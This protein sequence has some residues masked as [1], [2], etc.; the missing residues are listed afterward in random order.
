MRKQTRKERCDNL[1]RLFVDELIPLLAPPP[2][3]SIAEWADQN[4][5]LG[6]D[7]TSQPGPWRTDF[8]PYQRGIMEAILEPNTERIVVMKAARIGITYSAVLNPVGYYIDHNP[9]PL[10]VAYPTVDLAKKFSKKYLSPFLRDCK[11]ISGLVASP[12]SRDGDN[13]ML[14]K[15]FKN[16]AGTLTLIGVNSP[17]AMRMDTARFVVLDEADGEIEIREGNFVKLL[18]KRAETYIGRGKVFVIIS[19]PRDQATSVVEPEYLNSTMDQWCLPCPSCGEMQPLK[20][21]QI[22]FDTATHVCKEC[23]VLHNKREWL[24]GDGQ[25]ISQNPDATT[26]GFHINALP[27]PFVSWEAL[28]EDFR[29]AMAKSNAGDNSDLQ[30]FVNTVLAETWTQ[31][32]ARIDETGLMARREEYYADVPDGVCAITVAVDTQDNRLAVD[33]V[34]WGAG[35]ESWRLE[36]LELWGDTRVPGSPVW[37]Q[38]DEVLRTPR[39]YANG[40]TVPVVCTVI[41]MGGHAADQVCTYAKAR[42]GWNVWAIR[43]VGGWGKQLVHSTFKSKVASATAFNLAVDGGKDQVTALLRVANPGPGY[44]HFPR[45][46]TADYT[47]AYESVRGYDERYFAG[48]TAEKKVSVKVKGGFHRYEWQKQQGAANEPFDLAVYNLAAL[49]ISKV[50]LE[51]IAE[52]APW[53]L[54]APLSDVIEQPSE[55]AATRVPRAPLNQRAAVNAYTAV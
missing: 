17:N 5:W 39:A 14:L 3:I 9:G 23:G 8:A 44:C 15:M 12:R 29:D 55:R 41:D 30:V 36:Y 38:L 45:G 22:Q 54:D 37:A 16:G 34:G 18:E 24:A 50:N 7:V 21:K 33:V 48:L 31:P 46:G 6:T 26:R 43:G 53:M 32:G 27:S 51:R 28:I 4:V 11:A 49:T 10:L 19:T 2:D 47:G 1:L 42:M 13:T 40:V 35:K 20:W 52:K 25:W